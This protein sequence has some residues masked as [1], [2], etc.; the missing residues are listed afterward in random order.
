M[1]CQDS[2]R[3]VVCHLTAVSW[4]VVMQLFASHYRN[5]K[6]RWL[7]FKSVSQLTKHHKHWDIFPELK[8]VWNI[9][10]HLHIVNITA[11]NFKQKFWYIQFHVYIQHVTICAWSIASGILFNKMASWWH[12]NAVHI[13]GPLRG[14]PPFTDGY[15]SQRS[16][17]AEWWHS[18]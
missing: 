18:S 9:E 6:I 8:S 2:L 4:P 12:G 15:L 5:H 10:T 14:K 1:A 17:N 7:C 13:T 11:K 3:H 16:S